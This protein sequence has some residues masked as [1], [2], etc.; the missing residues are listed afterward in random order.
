MKNALVRAAIAACAVALLAA[1]CGG[2]GSGDEAD[3][4]DD[5]GATTT[6]AGSAEG[7]QPAEGTD[8]TEVEAL[9]GETIVDESFDDDENGW[10][11]DSGLP[12][13]SVEVSLEEGALAFSGGIEGQVNSWPHAFDQDAADLADQRVSATLAVTKGGTIG[14][15]CRL[16][17]E[18]AAP[19]QYTFNVS[20]AGTYDITKFDADEIDPI[21]L[22]SDPPELKE[23]LDDGVDP[24]DVDIE[25][26]FEF[27]QDDMHDVV[28]QCVD[29]DDGVELTMW[30]DDEQVLTA[31]DDDDPIESGLAGVTVDASLIATGGEFEEYDAMADDFEMVVADG[32][33]SSSGA[34][35]QAEPQDEPSGQSD[36]SIVVGDEIAT[37]TLEAQAIGFPSEGA[38]ETWYYNP[39]GLSL[40]LDEPGFTAPV[41][42][43]VE[44]PEEG[45]A[46]AV[47]VR[48]T[49]LMTSIEDYWGVSCNVS[50]EDGSF[51][52]FLGSGSDVDGEYEVLIVKYLD[53]EFEL[54]AEDT[55]ESTTNQLRIG[56]GCV[57]DDD[58]AMHLEMSV[59]D[60]RVL[61]HIDEDPLPAGAAGLYFESSEGGSSGEFSS[62]LVTEASLG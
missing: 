6:S 33:G 60:E 12:G 45:V 42:G 31:T 19:E 17:P 10:I 32:S 47:D 29:G 14:V 49:G 20:S 38:G 16:A 52:A 1:G 56:G 3:G 24:G 39:D 4:K 30:V 54:L 18:G 8:G 35:P 7:T 2:G 48:G 53:G 58:G 28:G 40:G 62:F 22:A 26:A 61:E 11:Y 44:V 5:K 21:T 27:D 59:G 23:Q 51:Y 46:V 15:I 25:P 43:E 13:R 36:A 9:D 55:V 37:A 34:D 57:T 41:A 50:S